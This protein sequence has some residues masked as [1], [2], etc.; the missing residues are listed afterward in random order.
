M[1][2][3]TVL[4]GHAPS[5]LPVVLYAPILTSS[6][7]AGSGRALVLLMGVSGS[8]KTTIGTLLADRLHAPFADADSFHPA[9]NIAKMA[10][11][12]P[13]T[14]DDRWPWLEAVA[15]WLSDRS[16]SE[17]GGV[18]TC[19]ALKRAYRDRLRLKCPDLRL[20]YLCGD[21]D[22]ISARQAARKDHFMPATLMASQLA[23]LEPPTADERAIEL[24][25][26]LAP[27]AIVE[28][29]LRGLGQSYDD[30]ER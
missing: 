3:K 24:S 11:G 16:T 4:R 1:V 13:L 18:V 6:I 9:A 5:A 20:L 14:D 17:G 27:D 30:S 19:S 10:R 25:I 12:E 22:T 15:N 8:G 21:A 7:M 28:E 26:S 2:P 29:A 23:T